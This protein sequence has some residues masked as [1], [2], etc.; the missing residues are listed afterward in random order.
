MNKPKIAVIGANEFQDPLIRKAKEMGFEVHAFAWA[1]GDVG[2]KSADVFHPISIVEKETICEVCKKEGVTAACSIG[3][4]LAIHTVNYIQRALGQPSNPPETD[5]IATNKYEMRKAFMAAV[6]PCPKFIKVVS[7]PAESELAGMRY[8]LIVKPTDRSGSRG[9]FKCLNYK[10]VCAAVEPSCA[11][12][13]EKCAIV[14]EYIS[15]TEYSCESISFA[16]VHHVLALTKKYTTGSPHFIETGHT[17]PSDIPEQW[18]ENVKSHIRMAL[19]ALHIRYGASHAEFMLDGDGG[20]HIIEIGSRMGGDCIGSDLVYLSTGMDFMR[21]VVD[22]ACG[23]APDL[24]PVRAPRRAEIR[25][26]F[27]PEDVQGLEQTRKNAP[28][29]LWRA[30][31]I[32]DMTEAVTDSSNRYGYYITMGE[33]L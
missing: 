12:S 20:V 29:T 7:V 30:S 33:L 16:G 1:A 19:D 18:Q 5:L 14:E 11:A 25:F 23:K 2:E 31:E 13:F 22:V 32:R 3:S 17:E 21:M 10:E 4:D 8:P 24:K 6:V 26:I 27:G 9:I 15:G 28:E